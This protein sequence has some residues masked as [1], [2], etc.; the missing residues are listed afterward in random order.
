M[1]GLEVIPADMKHMKGVMKLV[2]K[3]S[4]SFPASTTIRSIA[5]GRLF[6][7]LLDNLMVGFIEFEI[8]HRSTWTIQRLTVA[9]PVR[10]HKIGSSLVSV[11]VD[12]A[13][14]IGKRVEVTVSNSEDK[15]V[16]FWI[17]NHFTTKEVQRDANNKLYYV[18]ERLSSW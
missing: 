17:K 3:T 11:L 6:V 5:E 14:S 9:K 15:L 4:Y 2:S 1:A 12:E 13:Q 16:D 7:A 18:M 8:F 10:S